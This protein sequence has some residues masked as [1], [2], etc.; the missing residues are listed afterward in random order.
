MRVVR[1]RHGE[2]H[3]ARAVVVRHVTGAR[4]GNLQKTVVFTGM[5]ARRV[6]TQQSKVHLWSEVSEVSER[7]SV[8]EIVW[9]CG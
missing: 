9:V 7:V 2:V 8:R 5:G 6:L 3:W 4:P 1:Q